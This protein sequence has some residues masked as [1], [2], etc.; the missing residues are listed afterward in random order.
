MTSAMAAGG[1]RGERLREGPASL[2]NETMS[3]QRGACARFAQRHNGDDNLF[4]LF[5]GMHP[6][7][8]L[9]PAQAG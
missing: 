4:R 2:T 5:F 9:P 7:L 8:S 3:V 6:A 1:A